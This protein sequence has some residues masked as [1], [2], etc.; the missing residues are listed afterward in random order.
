MIELT[1]I[2]DNDAAPD[3]YLTLPIEQ[4][5]RSRLRV[6][7]DDGRDAGLFLP[8][9][10]LLR[11]GDRLG[12]KN[13]LVIEIIAADEPVS[14]VYCDD[15]ARLARAA[16]HLGNRHVP[17]QVEHGWLRYQ[18]DHVLDDMLRQMDLQPVTEQAPFEP[19]AGAYQQAAHTHTH[20]HEHSPQ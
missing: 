16:Y 3:G 20:S 11:G 12:G 5:V 10:T 8:R 19:E 13:G 9:G 4:R 1:C 7:L 6:T 18:H 17:L 2:V 14:T 15:L